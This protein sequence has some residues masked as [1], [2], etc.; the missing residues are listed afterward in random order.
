MSEIA[1]YWAK[2]DVY[3]RIVSALMQAGKS[4]DTLTI[5]DLSPVDHY[6]A[7]GRAATIELA[8]LLD[9]RPE[10]RILDIGCG[11]G[12][13][14]RY[15]AARYGCR[16]VGIDIAAP[17]VDAAERL[18]KLVG[19]TGQAT[20]ELGDGQ[21]LM[22]ENNSFDGVYTQHVTMNVADREGFFGE[23]FRVLKPGGFFA[24]TEH[25]RGPTGE[26]HFP[27]PWSDDGRFSF[28][29]TPE[30]TSDIL[31]NAGFEN[32]A[33]TDTSAKYLA[34]YNALMAMVAEKGLP[35]LGVHIL[36][37]PGAGEKTRN[38]ARNIDEGRTKPI[39]ILCK[40]PK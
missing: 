35:P 18:T 26:P 38:A 25:G 21:R 31:T 36:V 11:I 40:K 33:V 20:F 14:T 22:Q 17:F 4:I 15:I 37:G 6:H 32:I 19:L 9:I 30:E 24:L 16:V 12:G 28:L 29:S 23:A 5:D 27:A 7:R 2:D 1:D 13:P 3:E 8:D 39:L 34:A 10:H